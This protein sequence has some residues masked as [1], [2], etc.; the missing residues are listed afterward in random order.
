MDSDHPD[1]NRS[2]EMNPSE[3][4]SVDEQ[5][6]AP[7]HGTEGVDGAVAD[8]DAESAPD[9]AGRAASDSGEARGNGT[10][11]GERDPRSAGERPGESPDVVPDSEPG[12][13]AGGPD[14]GAEKAGE[15]RAERDRIRDRHLRLAADFDNYRKRTE[16]RLRR[17][18]D[19]A[20]AD[21]VFRLLEPLD[22][23][24]R[25]TALEPANASVEA[26][27][28]G[29]DLVERKFFR[30]LEEAGVEVVDPEGEVF[31]PNTM[32][33]I[34]RV[35]AGPDDDDDAVERVFQR[36]YTFAGRLVRPARVSVFKA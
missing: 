32:E 15:L 27:V 13:E 29:V 22:D 17:R 31:D 21:L 4:G 28:E 26:I 34:M 12:E 36:G 24:L 3:Q 23:L 9:G 11:G 19:R 5:T 18:W 6:R 16:D 14:L 33:A 7:E 8:D 30:V 10:P 35:P 1:T 20:Q 25:V 2:D